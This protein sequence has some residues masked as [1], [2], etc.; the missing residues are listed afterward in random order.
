GLLSLALARE[1]VEAVVHLT[2]SRFHLP[3]VSHT[4]HGRD[5]FAPV[6]AHLAKGVAITDFGPVVTDWHTINL[7][8]AERVEGQINGIVLEID[9]FGNLCTNIPQALIPTDVALSIKIAGYG[10]KGISATYGDVPPGKL[11]ALIGSQDTL[12][13]ACR[14][15]SAQ[16]K[17]GV[18]RGQSV[19]L[20]WQH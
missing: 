11:L 8:T 14:N 17:L 2:E 19:V 20:T 5:V 12:E 4:F 18:D 15:G 1:T 10:L 3:N 9:R 6:A 13:I 16:D 7:P